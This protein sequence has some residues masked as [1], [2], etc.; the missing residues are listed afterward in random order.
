MKAILRPEARL[1]ISET[2]E[3]Y[4]NQRPGLGL[5]FEL[6]VGDLIEKIVSHPLQ[7]PPRRFGSRIAIVEAF[8]YCLHFQPKSSEV[9]VFA[10]L[11]MS[12]NPKTWR[13]RAQKLKHR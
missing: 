6:A 9:I 3:W 1:D 13:S 7:F 5:Q 2:I 12:R 8:P 4:D 10:C 11:H